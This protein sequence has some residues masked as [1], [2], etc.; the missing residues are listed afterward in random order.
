MRTLS[1]LIG[2]VLVAALAVWLLARPQTLPATAFDGLAGDAARGERVFWVAGCASCHSAEGSRG[3]ELQVLAGGRAFE[4]D[5]GTFRAP[6]ISPDPEHGIG[7]WTLA[8]F[9]N[10]MLRGV[11]PDGGHYYPAFPYTSYARTGLQDLADLKAYMDTLPRAD[12]ASEPHDIEFPFDQR[13]AL[14]L[15]KRVYAR[16]EWVLDQDLDAPAKR[17]RYLVEALAH[18]GECHTPRD[19]WGGTDTRRWMAGAPNPSGRGSIPNISPAKLTWSRED[20]EAYLVSGFTPSFDVAG[21]SMAAVIEGLSRLPASDI[22]DIVA[23]L[24]AVPAA[25]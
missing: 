20:I 4:T 21:G 10:A 25:E 16:D 24:Q 7:G 9:G 13:W 22:A 12:R 8:E 6:N 18:C 14:G 19:R 11:A 17:G 15:W 1:W 23:Y 5:F 2:V 3:D